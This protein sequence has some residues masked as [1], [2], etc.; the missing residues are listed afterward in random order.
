MFFRQAKEYPKHFT[1]NN[2]YK[3]IATIYIQLTSL[4]YLLVVCFCPAI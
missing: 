4:A 3:Y 1:A 2:N